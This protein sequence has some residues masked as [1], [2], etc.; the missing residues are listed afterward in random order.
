MLFGAVL[1]VLVTVL[2]EQLA[3]GA[4][5]L[6]RVASAFGL[7]WAGL[8]IASGMIAVVGLGAVTKMHALDPQQATLAW[9][10]LSAV[11]DGLGGGVELVGGL[12]ITLLSIAALKQN[13]LPPRLNYL[14]LA[15][16][17]AG[18]LT[19]IALLEELGTLFG[20]GQIIWFIWLGGHLLTMARRGP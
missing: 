17:A 6:M 11:Q 2:H 19:I 3:V 14:G 1:V 4:P 16:G 18:V 8:V 7:I 5:T 10:T 15:I 13:L 20:L 9:Q 12:W